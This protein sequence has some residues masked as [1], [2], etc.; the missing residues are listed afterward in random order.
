MHTQYKSVKFWTDL[1][2][3]TKAKADQIHADLGQPSSRILQSKSIKV[4]TL[5]AELKLFKRKALSAHVR[6]V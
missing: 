6:G 1:N 5:C 3:A 2:L 4:E